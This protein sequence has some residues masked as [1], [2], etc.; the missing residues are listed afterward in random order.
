MIGAV[1]VL[2]VSIRPQSLLG[3]VGRKLGAV[4]P[5]EPPTAIIKR[6]N[7]LEARIEH[8]AQVHAAERAEQNT[9]ISRL[10]DQNRGLQAQNDTQARDVRDLR[11]EQADN[12]A[13]IHGLRGQLMALDR[14]YEQERKATEER[15][16]HNGERM[17]Q[18]ESDVKRLTALA[19]DRTAEA[20]RWQRQ[21]LLW[22]GEAKALDEALMAALP[23]TP[24]RVAPLLSLVQPPVPSE[25]KSDA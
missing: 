11:R 14:Q 20:Q 21:A 17:G 2:L 6:L 5:D 25:E 3:W 7:D 15:R 16:R 8:Q 22:Y 24:S 23:G 19:D 18:L 1:P 4:P 12:A 13:I 10:I 9:Q